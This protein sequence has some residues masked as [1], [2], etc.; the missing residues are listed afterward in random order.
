[1]LI[2][3]FCGSLLRGYIVGVRATLATAASKQ[4]Y[5]QETVSTVTFG[6]LQTEVRHCVEAAVTR[7][8]QLSSSPPWRFPLTAPA[9]SAVSMWFGTV[10][11]RAASLS[12]AAVTCCRCSCCAACASA[13]SSLPA[14]QPLQCSGRDLSASATA[15][16]ALCLLPAAPRRLWRTSL[17][18]WSRQVAADR[19]IPAWLPPVSQSTFWLLTWSLEHS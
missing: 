11:A 9:S 16:T 5:Q 8:A 1:M 12:A 4:I 15:R 14:L 3:G 2:N 13:S 19:S 6:T 17:P 10:T 18:P 7:A